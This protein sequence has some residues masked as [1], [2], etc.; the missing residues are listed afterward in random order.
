[1][2]AFKRISA[3]QIGPDGPK[4][5]T[6]YLF[7]QVISSHLLLPILTSTFIFSKYAKRPATL[8]SMCFTWILSGVVSSMLLYAGEFRGPE[9]QKGLCIAQAALLN[10]TVP[11]WSVA[12]LAF[13]IQ[14]RSALPGGPAPLNKMK[15]YCLLAAPYISLAIW[16]TACAILA[17]NDPV[18]AN[19]SRRYFYCSLK[20]DVFTN[21]MSLFTAIMCFAAIGL[22]VQIGVLLHRN[23][24]A[25]HR[26]GFSSRVDM[27]LI[28]RLSI[29]ELYILIGMIM[30]ISTIFTNRSTLPDLF[31]STIGFVGFLIFSLQ[32]DVLR[33]WAFWLP[34]PIQTPPPVYLSREPA[35][36]PEFDLNECEKANEDWT[37]KVMVIGRGGLVSEGMSTIVIGREDPESVTH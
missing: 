34:P 3:D 25:L 35:F 32:S 4:F 1:M 6:A 33:T 8:I 15:L 30:D 2:V 5:L 37:E 23:R 18:N 28:V 20:S 21:L 22:Q 36:N 26:A 27:Q 16:S 24:R 10:G 13:V 7:F 17:V 19:R 29:F 9:P 12:L 14:V 31:A 11:M